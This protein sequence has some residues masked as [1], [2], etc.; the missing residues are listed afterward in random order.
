[1][2]AAEL[3]V[4]CLENE[5]TEYIFGLPGEEN[6][7]ILEALRNSRIKFVLTRHEQGAAFMADVY[8]RLTGKAGV[9]LSTLGP[10][11]T[12]LFTGV[13]DANMDRAPLIAIT[14]QADLRR[15]HKES[16]QY[17]DIVNAFRPITKW[18]ARVHHADVIPEVI[19]KAFRIA[20]I[21]KKGAAHIEISEAIA[22]LDLEKDLKPLKVASN[23][24]FRPTKDAFE[25]AATLIK[26]S[27]NPIILAGNGVIRAEACRE[28]ADFAE[29]NRIYAAN[30]FMA[31]GA[32]SA[33]HE[34]FVSTIGLQA[35][36][37]IMC[38]FEKADLVIT[39]GYDIAE[40]SPAFWN[41]EGDKK[42]IHIDSVRAEVD[43]H[44]DP[45]VELVGE[46]KT[47]LYK[48]T[49]L[50]GFNKSFEYMNSLKKLTKGEFEEFRNS[51]HFPM[52]PQ[53]I[54]YDV[55][56]AL[57]DKDIILSDVGMHKLWIARL[58]PAYSP[59]TVIISNG[60]ATMGIALPGCVA[61]KLVHPDRKIVAITGDGG[62]LM[63]SQ[64]IETAKRLGL[65]FVV[66]IFSDS[67]YG[68]IE[69]KQVKEFGSEFGM[70]FT[71]PDFVMYA[72]SF[73][74]IGIRINSA[75]EFMPAL[76]KALETDNIVI[77]DVPVDY[78]E[79]ARLTEKLGKLVCP[80]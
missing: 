63:N 1:M 70:S 47:I 77:M 51:S 65:A 59:N 52:K 49:R 13:A 32:I 7:D 26:N 42:L 14:G 74:C 71:N 30:T 58:Y 28:L 16:H 21:E 8:G 17:I 31:K 56:Q 50:T 76:K 15:A 80:I 45:D 25:A 41:P 3:F 55:R 34:L 6:L 23:P 5:G 40:Y 79:N 29:K 69:W 66:I 61:A 19:R 36:D 12:N 67:K 39:V 38:G 10:G 35:K 73:G 24:S 60:F 48:L 37:Y 9:C 75:G 54:L 33:K 57:G 18:N 64:E 20:Q 72:E 4:K 68:M 11:A 2:K 53:K 43:A 22:C 27:K 46:M 78:S 44:Y 62:F